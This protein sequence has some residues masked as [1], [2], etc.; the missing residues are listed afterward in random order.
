MLLS[1]NISFQQKLQNNVCNTR[2]EQKKNEIFVCP[3]SPFFLHS[4]HVMI[5]VKLIRQ[6]HLPSRAAML[7][8]KSKPGIFNK[9]EKQQNCFQP[10]Y[11]CH[12]LKYSVPLAHHCTIWCRASLV[13]QA[14][15]ILPHSWILMPAPHMTP[16]TDDNARDNRIILRLNP[17]TFFRDFVLYITTLQPHYNTIVYSTNSVNNTVEP[18]PKL[19]MYNSFV[20][21]LFCYNTGYTLDPK[22]VL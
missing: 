2:V 1:G 13:V 15:A 21:T 10:H 12:H 14:W 5:I 7:W 19:P 3:V 9:F 18:W 20:I 22:T 11:Q 8:Q 16:T 17:S 4:V 6:N